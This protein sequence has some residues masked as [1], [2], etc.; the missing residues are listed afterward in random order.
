[1][2]VGGDK[3]VNVRVVE[4]IDT[5]KVSVALTR[6]SKQHTAAAAVGGNHEAINNHCAMKVFIKIWR[7]TD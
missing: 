2:G 3:E 5:R 7:C 1:M 4:I 6:S